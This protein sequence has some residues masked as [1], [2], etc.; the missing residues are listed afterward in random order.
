[1]VYSCFRRG[2]HLDRVCLTIDLV[3][4]NRRGRVHDPDN[5]S[6]K[7]SSQKKKSLSIYRLHKLTFGLRDRRYDL[8]S[9][10]L[11]RSYRSS[12]LRLRFDEEY[13]LPTG[14]G[15]R[16]SPRRAIVAGQLMCEYYFGS[17][18]RFFSFCS[19]R[20]CSLEV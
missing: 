15:E 1:M 19:I 10:C 16:V 20:G 5:V 4:D 12:S 6:V 14:D 2:N 17:S 8:P 7:F 3:A 13:V 9:S 18:N 11:L